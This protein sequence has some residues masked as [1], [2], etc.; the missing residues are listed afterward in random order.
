MRDA[1]INTIGEG[2]NDVL[3]AFVA[4]VGMRGVGEQLKGVRDALH[5]PIKERG[6]LFGFLRN[7]VGSRLTSPDV[8]V[9]SPGLHAEARELGKR[10]RDFGLAV[11]RVLFQ[12]REAV[13]ERQYV[14]ERLADAA[15][16]LYASS[17]TLSR[18]DHLLT[19]GNGNQ[20]EMGR[21]LTMGRYF[22]KLAS[23]RIRQSLAALWDN[24]DEQTTKAANAALER[25]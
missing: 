10:V 19:N 6:T 14:Q 13:L 18:L 4:L 25:F 5:S 12:Y 15:A 8:P 20:T 17:C 9:R 23:R 3:K 11:Q 7:Q 1:R 16:D 24:D 2:A 22:L 21:D